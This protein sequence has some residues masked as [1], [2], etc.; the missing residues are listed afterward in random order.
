M[1]ALN[2][3]PDDPDAAQ[4]RQSAI[5]TLIRAAERAERTGA[6][7]MAA[8]SYAMAARLTL[9]GAADAD[10]AAGERTDAG[11]SLGARRSGR[12]H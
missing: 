10:D 11:L 12:S 3:V 8:V 9:F 6:P 2:A 7:A 1:D 4:T 5:T